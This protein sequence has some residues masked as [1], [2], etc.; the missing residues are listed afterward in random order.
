MDIIIIF[1]IV[2]IIIVLILLLYIRRD[3]YEYM[4]GSCGLKYY[5]I[6]GSKEK[7]KYAAN[8]LCEINNRCIRL[9]EYLK[10]KYIE[11]GSDP[12][13]KK[14]VRKLINEYDVDDLIE[15]DTESFTIGKGDKIHICMR[16]NEGEFIDINDIMFVVVHELSHIITKSQTNPHT[17]EFWVNNIWLMREAEK[18]GIYKPI[19]YYRNPVKYCNGIIINRNPLFDKRFMGYVSREKIKGNESNI[20]S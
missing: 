1:I 11:K 10:H 5:V 6:N 3:K 16:N 2:A 7:S 20:E 19:D 14:M 15:N 9:I 17:S 13:K 4:T 12:E 8:L 18:I